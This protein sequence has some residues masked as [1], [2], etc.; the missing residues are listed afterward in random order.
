MTPIKNIKSP[1]AE[2][3]V[4]SSSVEKV[5]LK[6]LQNSQENNCKIRLKNKLYNKLK[7]RIQH[8]SGF[9]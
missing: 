5:L 7:N 6:I 3:V 9:L 4:W 8:S 2:A 1:T